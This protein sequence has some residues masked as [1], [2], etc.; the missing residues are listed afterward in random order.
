MSNISAIKKKNKSILI[1]IYTV[2]TLLRR[3][4]VKHYFVR[5]LWP[6]KNLLATPLCASLCSLRTRPPS[7]VPCIK[8]KTAKLPYE[9]KK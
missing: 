9:I 3:H 5:K 2:A 7:T 4:S 1:L 6:K 8:K